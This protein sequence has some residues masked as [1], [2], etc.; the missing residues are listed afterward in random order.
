MAAMVHG[1]NTFP[2]ALPTT[3]ETLVVF[4]SATCK[5][6]A[7]LMPWL[8]KMQ[9]ERPDILSLRVE[10][11]QA[12]TWRSRFGVRTIPAVFWVTTQDGAITGVE[13]LPNRGQ[14]MLS[15]VNIRKPRAAR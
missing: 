12:P 6:C 1:D 15:A 11:N 5:P 14:E 9:V 2:Q 8:D 4:K 13:R 10:Y 3:G 7:A